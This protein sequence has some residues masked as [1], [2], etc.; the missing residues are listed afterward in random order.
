MTPS[1]LYLPD[2]VLRDDRLA[3]LRAAD[4]LSLAAAPTFAC[5]AALT[6][7]LGGGA[8]EMLCSATTHTSVLSGMVPMY[9]LMSA[10]HL[11]PWLKLIPRW[12]SVARASTSIRPESN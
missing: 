4:W 8:D 6:S 7:I 11:A 3:N 1:T 5:M 12:R 2:A 9:L 10:F